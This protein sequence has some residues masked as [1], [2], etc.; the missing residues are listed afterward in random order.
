[1]DR[2]AGFLQ[3]ICA[4]P[5]DDTPR[6]IYAD[7]LEEHAGPAEATRA[8]LIRVQ[9]SC[10]RLAAGDSR[11]P[12]LAARER[13]LLAAHQRTWRQALPS[14]TGIFW[15]PFER[16]FISGVWADFLSLRAHAADVFSAAPIQRL[17]LGASAGTRMSELARMDWLTRISA[18]D[19]HDSSIGP[20]GLNALLSSPYLTRLRAFYLANNSLGAEGT[21]AL[22]EAIPMHR[23][24]VL[25]LERNS[26]GDAGARA[27][28]E[29]FRLSRLT[30]LD[31]AHNG[32]GNAGATQL[33]YSPCLSN[34]VRLKLA[35]NVIGEP[36]A[37]S[38]A[39]SPMWT[40]LASL[41][42]SA[43]AIGTAALQALARRFRFLRG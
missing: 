20:D 18:L 19:L 25:H 30:V 8:E 5:D 26:I 15:G 2:H 1:V 22:A 33:A 10:A 43:N 13:E 31:L 41:D 4:D 23:L 35:G 24:Q 14:L 27:L 39:G 29:S 32:I 40:R 38:L 34:L 11:R 7:W 16:G 3:D 42:L 17:W 6:L 21:R 9:I 37:L 36:G 12:A 28:A